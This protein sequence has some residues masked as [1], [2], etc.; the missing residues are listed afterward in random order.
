MGDNMVRTTGRM[1]GVE[2]S[3]C[4]YHLSSIS[5]VHEKLDRSS[6]NSTNV[7]HQSRNGI[8][9]EG[10]AKLKLPDKDMSPPPPKVEIS[11]IIYTLICLSVGVRKRQ[12][13]I[14]AR[15]P[16]GDVSN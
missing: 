12:V 2:S 6:D 4:H 10:R 11:R 15:S 9:G 5:C 7:N 16:V 13:A 1:L 3:C 14:L 8:S